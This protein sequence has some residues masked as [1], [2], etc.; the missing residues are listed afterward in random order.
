MSTGWGVPE[1]L[2]YLDGAL[3]LVLAKPH[4]SPLIDTVHLD[5]RTTKPRTTDTDRPEGFDAGERLH[6]R[7][8]VAKR[9][10]A[11]RL[12][13]HCARTLL[14]S[15]WS[16]ALTATPLNGLPGVIASWGRSDHQ[17]GGGDIGG[18]AA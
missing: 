3:R 17:C 4:S 18:R 14:A 8:S 12:C 6:E 1:P 15:I 7:G 2:P 11:D 10:G 5:A 9:V 13:A 16:F